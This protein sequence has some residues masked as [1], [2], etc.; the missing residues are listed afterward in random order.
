MTEAIRTTPEHEPR[1]HSP[2]GY[3]ASLSDYNHAILHGVW[4]DDLTDADHVRGEIQKMLYASEEA[5]AEEY[6]LHDYDGF[7]DW[8]PSEYEPI[9]NLSKVAAGIDEHGPAFAA[10]VSYLGDASDDRVDNFE[11]AYRGHWASMEAFAEQMVED[12]GLNIQDRLPGWISNYVRI[13]YAML[14]RDMAID[15]H[16]TNDSTGGVWVFDPNI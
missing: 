14:G 6:A 13:D 7:G 9:E 8:G 3:F 5:V 16:V 4:I 15:M 12:H 10:W 1:H 11:D 2:R